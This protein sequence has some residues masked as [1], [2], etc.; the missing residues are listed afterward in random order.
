M[1]QK[2]S[3][4]FCLLLVLLPLQSHAAED[5]PFVGNPAP[6]FRLADLQGNVHELAILR[7]S[8]HVLVLFW[9]TNCHFCHA[10]IPQFK[11]I[12]DTY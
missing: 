5:R 10:M 7:K 3:M 4:V 8:Q 11:S 1:Q 9:S 6:E 2:L 12:Q